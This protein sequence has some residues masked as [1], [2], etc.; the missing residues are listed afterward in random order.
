MNVMLSEK[1]LHA[2]VDGELSSQEQQRV[3]AA[4][5]ASEQL[6]EQVSAVHELKQLIRFVYGSELLP[7]PPEA[8][9]GKIE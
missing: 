2:Y 1:E 8:R 5:V 9:V 6:A 3:T 7:R 4:V